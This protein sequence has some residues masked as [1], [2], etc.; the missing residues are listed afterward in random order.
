MGQGDYDEKLR[1]LFELS[2][3]I[4]RRHINVKYVDLRFANSVIVKPFKEAVE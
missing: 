2:D 3:E 1:R 4:K